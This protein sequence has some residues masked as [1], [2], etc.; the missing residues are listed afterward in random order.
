MNARQSVHTIPQKAT[1][2]FCVPC[3]LSLLLQ[4]T[5]VGARLG[6]ALFPSQPSSCPA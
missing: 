5:T 3:L 6:P 1:I 4:I 2:C